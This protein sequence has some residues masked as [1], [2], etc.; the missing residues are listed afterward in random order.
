MIQIEDLFR[1]LD[2]RGYR[3]EVKPRRSPPW[4]SPETWFTLIAF[5]GGNHLPDA[6][7]TGSDL[8]RAALDLLEDLIPKVGQ[9]MPAAGPDEIIA[10]PEG[11]MMTDARA[12]YAPLK[13]P[14]RQNAAG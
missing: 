12:A 6:T 7:G 8:E 5:T 14:G 2:S 9:P 11:I 3:I 4:E 1:I 10:G 13:K